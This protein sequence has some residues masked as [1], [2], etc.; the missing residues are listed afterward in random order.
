MFFIGQNAWHYKQLRQCQ[1][2]FCFLLLNMV[3][4]VCHIDLYVT[5]DFSPAKPLTNIKA[6]TFR[7]VL[8]NINFHHPSS[9]DLPYVTSN[10][11]SSKDFEV[12]YFHTV[13]HD[14]GT[15]CRKQQWISSL[16]GDAYATL[17]S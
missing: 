8:F 11:S 1:K 12:Y 14:H 7:N 15:G 5:V 16:S 13:P 9:P 10:Q 3:A 17:L 2:I 4:I 6:C